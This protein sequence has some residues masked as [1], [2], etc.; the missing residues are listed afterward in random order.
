[1]R[2]GDQP[3]GVIPRMSAEQLTQQPAVAE[4]RADLLD[5]LASRLPEG[6]DLEIETDLLTDELLDSL[7]IMELV[8]HAEAMHGAAL[9][10]TDITPRNFRTVR[11]IAN[12]IIE[13][14]A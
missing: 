4:I 8:A 9:A 11:T 13:R 5:F 2:R 14:R 7:L 10:N 3:D 6:S 12:L 1:M